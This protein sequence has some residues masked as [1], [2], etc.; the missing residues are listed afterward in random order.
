MKGHII[1]LVV[2]TIE[3]ETFH[4][5]G[6]TN[7]FWVSKSTTAH[8]DPSPRLAP[9][10]GLRATPYHSLFELFSALS[11]AFVKGLIPLI[12]KNNPS[13]E[14]SDIFAAVPISHATPAASWLVPTPIHTADPFRTQLAYL[15]TGSTQADLLPPA[16]DWN[17]DAQMFKELP[18]STLQQKIGRE[19]LISR[20]Q[21][22]FL[23]AATK[24]VMSI[25]RGDIPPLNPNEPEAAHTFVHNNMLFTRAEDTFVRVYAHVGGDEASRVAA[26]KD[27]RGVGI[28]DRLEVPNL[29]TM[30]TVIVDYCGE[31]YVVQSLIPGLFKT[32]EQEEAAVTED[33]P[34]PSIMSLDKDDYPPSGT[35]RIVY[36]SAV[37]ETPDQLV[38]S[39][40]YFGSLAQKVAEQLHLAEHAVFDSQGR[41]TQL[42]LSTD[43]HGIAGPDGRSYVIDCCTFHPT[44]LFRSCFI[45]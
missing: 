9:P 32:K 30:A 10:R 35:F 6:A 45:H 21:A 1:Y 19:R 18:A 11:P 24:G 5:T 28:L 31:R 33:K 42:W 44:S 25:I 22:D 2:T 17:D 37:P 4:V 13:G 34:H 40:G 26:L 36:G 15:L 16:R 38:R 3:G 20:A 7:G 12:E 43:V 27:L 8:F 14:V 39:S 29:Y 23:A 41:E